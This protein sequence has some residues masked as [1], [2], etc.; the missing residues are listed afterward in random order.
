MKRIKAL[1][2]RVKAALIKSWKQ[3]HV[4]FIFEMVGTLFTILASLTLAINAKNPNMLIVFP[5]YEIGAIALMVAYYRREMVWSIA[6]TAY[7]IVINIV[8]FV[9]VLI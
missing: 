2:S 3:D 1:P 6:L 5:L 7:F 4:A 8:G 9:V